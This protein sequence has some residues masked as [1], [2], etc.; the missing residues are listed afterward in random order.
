MKQARDV[1]RCIAGGLTCPVY[2][3]AIDGFDTHTDQKLKH[4][5]L[6]A[7]VANAVAAL[8]RALIG[9]GK[10]DS[11]LV[12][13]YSEFGRRTDENGGGGTDHGAAAPQMV[14]GGA[15][16]GGVYG[17]QPTLV[18][19]NPWDA[20]VPTLDFRRLGATCGQWLGVASASSG[21]G[22]DPFDAGLT[23]A[24]IEGLL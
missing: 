17:T 6:L 8:R 24:A 23:F 7:E 22:V 12:M 20:L 11:T 18:S 14:F 3:L 21:T 15:I 13:T 5:D 19:E 4:A 10:W 9:A 16:A 2:K 1:F